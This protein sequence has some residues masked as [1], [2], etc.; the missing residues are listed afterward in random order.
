MTITENTV[1]RTS[2]AN[3][4]AG[5]IR[6]MQEV[7]NENNGIDCFFRDYL[8]V[9]DDAFYSYASISFF[10]EGKDMKI[11]GENFDDLHT[12]E[13]DDFD[14]VVLV[15]AWSGFRYTITKVGDDKWLRSYEGAY[16]GLNNQNLLLN[17]FTI[18]EEDSTVDSSYTDGSISYQ[19]YLQLRERFSELEEEGYSFKESYDIVNGTEL[20]YTE[21]LDIKY[22]DEADAL[23]TVK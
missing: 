19:S 22:L 11:V 8:K 5:V 1:I 16:N 15:T 6:E 10:K 13:I 17:M 20:L 18:D 9:S 14:E 2:S 23:A 4:F 12:L 21:E 7:N 3:L